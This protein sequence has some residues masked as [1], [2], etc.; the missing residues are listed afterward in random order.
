MKCKINNDKW[1][2]AGQTYI[3]HKFVRRINSTAVELTLEDSEGF[4]HTKV[5]AYHQIEW[6]FD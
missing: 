1:E 6:L 4:I 3:V 5:A 2:D